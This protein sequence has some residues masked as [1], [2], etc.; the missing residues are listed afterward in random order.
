MEIPRPPLLDVKGADIHVPHGSY[1]RVGEPPM[2]TR[3]LVKL[4]LAYSVGFAMGVGL[5][6]VL[7]WLL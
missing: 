2:T 1:L 5:T 6:L 7:G 4:Y 3:Q